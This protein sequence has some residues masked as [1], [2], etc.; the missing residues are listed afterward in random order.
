IIGRHLELVP[1]KRIVQAWRVVPWDPGIYSIARFQLNGQDSKTTIVF[2]HTGF[3]NGLGQH[4]ADGWH[5]NY[6][7]P[8][9]KYLG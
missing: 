6:W 7:E 4:L 2:D 9:R 5:Q 1:D 8:L 3:P